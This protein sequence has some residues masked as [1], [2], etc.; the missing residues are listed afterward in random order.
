MKAFAEYAILDEYRTEERINA[1]LAQLAVDWQGTTAD[2]KS[3]AP[4][5]ELIRLAIDAAGFP[6]ESVDIVPS[7]DGSF[8]GIAFVAVDE[9]EIE[10]VFFM[11]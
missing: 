5:S 3:I 1:A 7:A 11:Q 4:D 9:D 2:H 8:I 6:L 10:R